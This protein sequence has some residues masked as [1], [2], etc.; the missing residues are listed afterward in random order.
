MRTALLVIAGF[1][2][3]TSLGAAWI[4]FRGGMDRDTFIMVFEWCGVA[5]FLL[6][7]AWAYTGRGQ[8]E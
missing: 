5:W 1:S 2:L 7:T 4:H 6:A 3:V 8:A